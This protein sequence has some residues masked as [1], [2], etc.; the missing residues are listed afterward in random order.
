M[1]FGF[2]LKPAYTSTETVRLTKMAE[3]GGFEY[4]WLFDTHVLFREPY[5]LLTLM[6]LNRKNEAIESFRKSCEAGNQEAC[7]KLH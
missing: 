6:A 3:D 5:P 4:G 2:C 7:K 1:Q